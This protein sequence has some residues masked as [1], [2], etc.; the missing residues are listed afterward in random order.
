MKKYRVNT[1]ISQKHHELL[2]EFVG[3]YGTQQKVLEHALES[4]KNNSNPVD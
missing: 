1:T 3:K 4:L 2:K